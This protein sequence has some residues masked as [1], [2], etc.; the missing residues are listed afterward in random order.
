[1]VK[2]NNLQENL[3]IHYLRKIGYSEKEIAEE[4]KK[5]RIIETATFLAGGAVGIVLTALIAMAWVQLLTV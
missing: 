5:D 4:I 3:K 2:G 1:M